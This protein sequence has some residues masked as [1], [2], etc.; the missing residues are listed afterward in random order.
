MFNIVSFVSLFSS[1]AFAFAIEPTGS[2][3]SRSV[4]AITK[5]ATCTPASAGNVNTDDVPAI[6]AA[7]KSCGTRGT[8]V[9]P[10]GKTYVIRSTLDFTGC[11][12]CDFQV[13]GTLKASDD[14]SFW[15]GVDAIIS[16]KGITGATI[17]SLTGSGIID[18]NG[19]ASYDKFASDPSYDRPKLMSITG[20]S[21]NIAVKGLRFK[22]PPCESPRLVRL[23]A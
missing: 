18:G 3:Y 5:R 21:S 6:E 4:D 7:L 23:T 14:T 20:K 19:Q 12:N 15:N 13:E 10:A 9:I 1:A 17:R 8:I 11:T 2:L 16:V 22:N